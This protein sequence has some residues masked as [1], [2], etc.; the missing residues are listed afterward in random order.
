MEDQ[1]YMMITVKDNL[2]VGVDQESDKED[3]KIRECDNPKVVQF[4]M[5]AYFGVGFDTLDQRFFKA[6][7]FTSGEAGVNG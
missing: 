7:K 2:L 1:D 6:I 4:F 3:V 5:M